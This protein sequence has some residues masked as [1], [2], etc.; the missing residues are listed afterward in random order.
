MCADALSLTAPCMNCPISASANIAA[1]L[2]KSLTSLA[3]KSKLRQY[4]T[5][6]V[7]SANGT[8]K[9]CLTL[10]S[11]RQGSGITP[12]LS[13]AKAIAETLLYASRQAD[14]ILFREELDALSAQCDKIHV[15][16]VL[17]GERRE[18]YEI[19]PALSANTRRKTEII[20]CSYT[21]RRGCMTLSG[22][23]R[24]SPA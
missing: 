11:P 24:R 8:A 17:T 22:K 5:R 14:G 1:D 20:P 4:R 16:Y 18:G 3:R 13:M 21:A 23:R 10:P 9:P 15:V 2:Q 7:T 6:S 19:P 12:F